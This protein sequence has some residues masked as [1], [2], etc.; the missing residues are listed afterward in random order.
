MRTPDQILTGPRQQCREDVCLPWGCALRDT[1][2]RSMSTNGIV[3]KTWFI[4]QETGESCMHYIHRGEAS[5]R[6]EYRKAD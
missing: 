6:S 2:Q 1:C 3:V 4:P 5:A